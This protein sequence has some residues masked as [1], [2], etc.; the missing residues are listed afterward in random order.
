MEVRER[1]RVLPVVIYTSGLVLMFLGERVFSTINAA[2]MTMSLAGF[3]LAVAYLVMRLRGAM[4]E[5]GDRR[6]IDRLLS[7]FALFTVLGLALGF[8]TTEAGEKLIKMS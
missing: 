1:S 3:G 4:V 8:L 5:S 7:V 6:A 2:R